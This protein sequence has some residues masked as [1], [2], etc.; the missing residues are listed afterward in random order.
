MET[1]TLKSAVSPSGIEYVQPPLND[2]SDLM[3]MPH[4]ALME[5]ALAAGKRYDKLMGQAGYDDSIFWQNVT[6]IE[7]A[8]AEFNDCMRALAARPE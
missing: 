1:Q 4:R 5:K 2:I 7:T 6:E 3:R 8:F